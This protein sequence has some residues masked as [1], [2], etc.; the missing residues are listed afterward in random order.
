MEEMG[1]GVTTRQVNLEQ[2]IKLP[3]VFYEGAMTS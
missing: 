2:Q 1:P 3:F